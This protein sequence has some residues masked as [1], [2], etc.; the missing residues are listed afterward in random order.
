MMDYHIPQVDLDEIY[1]ARLL[2]ILSDACMMDH[3]MN[4]ADTVMKKAVFAKSISNC[5]ESLRLLCQTV[6][7]SYGLK[8]T[9]PIP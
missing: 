3:Y 5:E 6:N 9:D 4:L 7:N 8:N 2:G 1:R